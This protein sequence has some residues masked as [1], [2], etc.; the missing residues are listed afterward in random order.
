[1][2]ELKGFERVSLAPGEK[3]TVHFALGKDE[4]SYWSS[5]ENKWVEEASTFDIWAGGDSTAPL[6]ATFKLE[7]P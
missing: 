1:M 2:R 6:H 5:A 4:L 7:H 3:K